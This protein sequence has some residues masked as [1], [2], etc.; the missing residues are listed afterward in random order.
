MHRKRQIHIFFNLFCSL[1]LV[2][3]L[4]LLLLLLFVTVFQRESHLNNNHSATIRVES[5][6]L[7][8]FLY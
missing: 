4:L 7:T 2:L 5:H 6:F 3:L 1:L 8:V